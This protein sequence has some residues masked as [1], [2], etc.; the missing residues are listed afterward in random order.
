MQQTVPPAYQRA[1]EIR[2]WLYGYVVTSCPGHREIGVGSSIVRVPSGTYRWDA[3]VD[4]LAT[5]MA[6][7][8]WRA[9]I[10]TGVTGGLP[11]GGRILLTDQ[12]GGTKSLRAVDCLS[13]MLGLG[14]EPG[15]VSL[16]SADAFLAPFLPWGGVP[17][18]GATWRDVTLDRELRRALDRTG[19]GMGYGW[20]GARLWATTLRMSRQALEVIGVPG[21]SRGLGWMRSGRVAIVPSA[22]PSTPMTSGDPHGYLD[23][24][25]VQVG[26]PRWQGP[27]E[28]I[29]EVPMIVATTTAA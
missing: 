14:M 8:G 2:A 27:L 22:S 3:F 24:R 21:V 29:A 9:E 7:V 12:G 6:A 16:K 10:S 28:M 15:E 1:D 20:G 17:L 5:E 4:A 18:Y 11:D 26:A 19:R 25:I 13:L 23:G